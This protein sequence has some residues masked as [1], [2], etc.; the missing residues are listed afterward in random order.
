MRP[1]Q[2]VVLPALVVTVSRLSQDEY[3]SSYDEREQV[4]T[5]MD[6]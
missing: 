4:N 5:A 3:D 2:L 1:M 6:E